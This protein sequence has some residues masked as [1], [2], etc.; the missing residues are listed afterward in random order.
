MVPQHLRTLFWDVNVDTFNPFAH[1]VYT[2][3]RV[4]EYGDDDDVAWLRA[5]F[6]ASEITEVVRHE[7]R[8][9]RRSANFWALLYGIPA[10]DITALHDG[11]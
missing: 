9:S 10:G 4:L 6:S 5:N 1:A 3:G 2:I 7:R 11:S 8:L